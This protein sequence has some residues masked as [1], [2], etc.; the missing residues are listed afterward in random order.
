MQQDKRRQPR[1]ASPEEVQQ[2]IA[3]ARRLIKNVDQAL[4]SGR[5][6]FAANGL[7][8]RLIANHVRRLYGPAGAAR[9]RAECARVMAAID[10]S[11]ER[12]HARFT[13][14]PPAGGGSR[15]PRSM[16]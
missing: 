12:A 14:Q 8:H 2:V 9:F 10:R 4:E 1:Q 6:Y 3:D 16:V 13:V 7:D 15:R 5:R 11:V